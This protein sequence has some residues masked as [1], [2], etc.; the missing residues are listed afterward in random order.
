MEAAERETIITWNDVEGTVNVFTCHRKIMAKMER[1]GA[2][3]KDKCILA[4]RVRHVE[5][6][7]DKS[8]I[9][10]ILTAKRRAT[11]HEIEKLKQARA[12]SPI[13]KKKVA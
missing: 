4:G 9:N 12:L 2:T 11:A 5:Y 7:I 10:V 8:K 1:L 13:G 6:E 3:V